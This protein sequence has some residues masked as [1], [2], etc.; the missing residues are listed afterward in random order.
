MPSLQRP[1]AP[2]KNQDT[3]GIEGIGDPSNRT[4]APLSPPAAPCAPSD[5]PNTLPMASPH[6]SRTPPQRGAL[7]VTLSAAW[8]AWPFG[9]VQ[10]PRRVMALL[11]RVLYNGDS[12][13]TLYTPSDGDARAATSATVQVETQ[14][15][16]LAW[17]R[18]CHTIQYKQ[19]RACLSHVP[20][21]RALGVPGCVSLDRRSP[22]RSGLVTAQHICTHTKSPFST[23]DQP[24][25]WAACTLSVQCSSA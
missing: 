22:N 24:Y 23:R 15:T 3:F 12:S 13:V 25:L 9:G 2:R 18:L 17:R 10:V 19:T 11:T 21:A 7:P 1:Q 16:A 4:F 8:N 14:A 6:L 5:C 20:S